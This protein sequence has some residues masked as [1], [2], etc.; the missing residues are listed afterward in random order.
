MVLWTLRSFESWQSSFVDTRRTPDD[1][2]VTR[3]PRRRPLYADFDSDAITVERDI[4]AILEKPEPWQPGRPFSGK[5]AAYKYQSRESENR[6][7]SLA[8]PRLDSFLSQVSP[9][10]TNAAPRHARHF[11]SFA[12]H[13]K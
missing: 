6:S 9:E 1:E 3:S 5:S 4:V 10:R 7:D 11:L 2:P 8:S 13:R 12:H